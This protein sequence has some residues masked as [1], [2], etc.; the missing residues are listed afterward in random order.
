MPKRKAF[1]CAAVNCGCTRRLPGDNVNTISEWM[2]RP[3]SQGERIARLLWKYLLKDWGGKK[4]S[5]ERERTTT[6]S[7]CLYSEKA[8][9]SSF[10]CL[11]LS[12]KKEPYRDLYI[13]WQYKC[14]RLKGLKREAGC[15]VDFKLDPECCCPAQN[16][17]GFMALLVF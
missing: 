2:W 11:Q 3:A 10:K 16:S 14:A 12:G 9:T 8:M 7:S 13:Y 17:P 4:D 6:N 15:D 1:N 5:D